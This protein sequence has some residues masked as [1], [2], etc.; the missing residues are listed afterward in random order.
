MASPP[1]IHVVLFPFMSKGHTIPIFDLARILLNR[2]IAITIFT[3]PANRPFFAN[4]LSDTNINIIDI[5]FP[6]NI[7]G[8]PAGVESTDKLPSMSLFVTFANTTKSM[9]PHFEKALQSLLPITFMVTDGFLVWTLESANKF[10]IPRLAYYGMSAFSSA[11]SH[12]AGSVLQ[13]EVSDDEPFAV[14]NFPSIKLTRNDFDFPFRE[15]E[16]K[17]PLFE[18]TMEAIIATSKSYGLLVNSFYELESV[19]ADY[20]NRISTSKSWCVGPFCAVHEPPKEKQETLEKPSYIKWLD[21]M[22][23]QGKPVLY[24][25]FG[26]QAELSPEQFKEIKIGLEKSEVNFLW[27][28]RR[29]A[30]SEPNDEFENRVKNRGLVM[31]EWVD[32]R[33]ILSHGSVQ[34]FLSHCGWNSVIESICAK[35]PILAWPMMAEQHLNARMIVEVIKI[36]L[37]VETCDGS[38][39]GFVKWEGLEKPIRKLMEGEKG[40]EAMKKVKEI[41]V[42]AINAV[43]EGGTSWQALNELIHELS[44]RGQV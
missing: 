17:G 43:K 15:R 3:T 33:E 11:M 5:P 39:R 30:I 1:C 29:S 10:G 19:Y 22:L 26:S 21:E 16:S 8:I 2:K 12:S 42:A 31:T 28:V 38:V 25:A 41:G 6:E 44:G 37:R 32:Q 27:V 40:K 18:F 14:P 7:Q 9:K 23:E 35:V 13:T 4:S 34:G 24:V 36:G 20:C